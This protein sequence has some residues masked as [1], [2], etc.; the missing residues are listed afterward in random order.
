MSAKHVEELGSW[1]VNLVADYEGEPVPIK[2]L[3]TAVS[4]P[5]AMVKR[6][7]NDLSLDRAPYIALTTQG[8]ISSAKFIA[9][10]GERPPMPE[11][12][13][14]VISALTTRK[15]RKKSPPSSKSPPN[16]KSPATTKTP[17]APGGASA[18]KKPTTK[19]RRKAGAGKEG[20][21]NAP[22]S[23]SSVNVEALRQWLAAREPGAPHALSDIA[24]ELNMSAES[25]IAA[26]RAL[27]S[28]G[29]V[30]MVHMELDD[31]MMLTP[32]SGIRAS[33]PPAQSLDGTAETEEQDPNPAELTSTSADARTRPDETP[34]S[35]E[36]AELVDELCRSLNIKPAEDVDSNLRLAIERS[37]AVTA[38]L[39]EFGRKSDEMSLLALKARTE[40]Y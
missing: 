12:T 15:S 10:D 6:V 39:G 24:V 22:E 23:P 28:E 31:E 16:R 26:A 33:A 35:E 9:S 36:V 37:R 38:L 11:D 40:L 1:L 3:S 30:D 32:R 8:G 19:P 5:E 17:S 14:K 7:L 20:K 18:Q 4:L 27:E 13:D 34:V 21:P 25:A 29:M 2:T